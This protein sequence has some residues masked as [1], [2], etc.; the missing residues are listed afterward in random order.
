MQV[1]P[2]NP[3][4]E[5][6][7]HAWLGMTRHNPVHAAQGHEKR[8]DPSA[9]TSGAKARPSCYA[10]FGTA[11]AVPSRREMALPNLSVLCVLCGE[12]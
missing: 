6:T 1:H 10:V 2:R 3:A 5:K 8:L 7:L 4:D 9:G 11:E 12:E